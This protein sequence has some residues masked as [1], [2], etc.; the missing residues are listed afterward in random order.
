M[1]ILFLVS[2]QAIKNFVSGIQDTFY[3]QKGTPTSIAYFFN[4]LLS[5]SSTQIET[6]E[7]A[8]YSV[9]ITHPRAL[10]EQDYTDYYMEHVHPVGTD[11]FISQ[12]SGLEDTGIA[13]LRGGESGGFSGDI[14]QFTA[15][16]EL[17][18]GDGAYD[19]TGT[20]EEISILGN[21]FP[22]TLGD[23]SAIAVSA[24]CS[25]STAHGGISGGAT[26]NTAN[27]LTFTFPDWSTAYGISGSSFGLINI[28]EFAHLSAASGNT[29]PNDGI[30]GN[31]SCPAG[32]YS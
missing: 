17:V 13:F 10:S 1:K 11:V 26:G 8:S 3:K 29:S 4:T 15:W 28:Y 14:P 2:N 21:Y 23:T 30:V 12:Q 22:Y 27:M 25:G 19:G 31:Y 24:G 16:E 32:G 5:A 20:G 9:S 7:P 18:Y 6:T